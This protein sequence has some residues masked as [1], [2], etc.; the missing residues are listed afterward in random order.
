MR[1][2][3]VSKATPERGQRTRIKARPRMPG[4]DPQRLLQCRYQRL[5]G[6]GE[7]CLSGPIGFVQ[8]LHSG[9]SAER[10]LWDSMD[11]VSLEQHMHS[12][13]V[14]QLLVRLLTGNFEEA[15][16]GRREKRPPPFRD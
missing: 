3:T 7:G 9:R 2:S 14:G 16:A 12:E 6:D 11:A 8:V 1:P 5:I 10:T 4:T 13:G 15:V